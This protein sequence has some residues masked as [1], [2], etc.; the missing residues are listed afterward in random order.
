MIDTNGDVI[1]SF[2]IGALSVMID[3]AS[4]RSDITLTH[5]DTGTTIVLVQDAL[6]N[7]DFDTDTYIDSRGTSLS[8]ACNDI[9]MRR[10]TFHSRGVADGRSPI[11]DIDTDVRAEGSTGD[12]RLYPYHT[13]DAYC[14]ARYTDWAGFRFFNFAPGNEQLGQ[15]IEADPWGMLTTHN[16]IT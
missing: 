12:P 13:L 16:S 4:L 1:T 11:G 6:R 14:S 15:F 7:S 10:V 3:G 9:T 5:L 2:P 8:A